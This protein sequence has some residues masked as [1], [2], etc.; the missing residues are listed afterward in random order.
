MD[1]LFHNT[2]GLQIWMSIRLLTNRLL[3]YCMPFGKTNTRGDLCHRKSLSGPCSFVTITQY[4]SWD[5][6]IHFKRPFRMTESII[7]N[8][9]LIPGKAL[10]LSHGLDSNQGRDAITIL[11]CIFY[12]KFTTNICRTAKIQ[13]CQI[14]VSLLFIKCNLMGFSLNGAEVSFTVVDVLPYE[15]NLGSLY[16]MDLFPLLCRPLTCFPLAI[17]LKS[18]KKVMF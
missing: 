3:V 18:K 17:T 8:I 13:Q 5:I 9:I 11:F 6:L 1:F 12:K 15:L 16:L 10:Q 7:Q 4:D 14:L 2:S